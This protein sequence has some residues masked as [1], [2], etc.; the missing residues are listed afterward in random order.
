MYYCI[1]NYVDTVFYKLALLATFL[2]SDTTEGSVPPPD[3]NDV[4]HSVEASPEIPKMENE[5]ESSPTNKVPLPT[6]RTISGDTIVSV[7]SDS[8][9]LI[10]DI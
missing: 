3:S 7:T 4:D 1:Y 9:G 5:V 8:A 6:E 2:L 10:P